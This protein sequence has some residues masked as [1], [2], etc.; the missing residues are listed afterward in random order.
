MYIVN[1]HCENKKDPKMFTWESIHV[2][3][4]T[5]ER[6]TIKMEWAITIKYSLLISLP[7][8]LYYNVF[9]DVDKGYRMPTKK[10]RKH[11]STKML[12]HL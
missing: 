1:L 10:E 9:T 3:T 7:I 2:F 5:N 12:K 8:K 4:T 6:F 11:Q